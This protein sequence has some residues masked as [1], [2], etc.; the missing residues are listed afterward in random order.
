M[1]PDLIDK[2]IG[3][4]IFGIG[5]WIGHSLLFLTLMAVIV[6]S[7]LKYQKNTAWVDRYPSQRWV[8]LIYIGSLAHLLLD[9]PGINHV[10]VFWPFFGPFPDGSREGFLLGYRSARTMLTE[11]IGLGFL[12]YIGI[13]EKWEKIKW[14]GLGLLLTSYIVL[15]LIL[16][17]LLVGF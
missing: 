8:L 6:S 13:N 2:T 16:F 7:I 3:S 4:M 5:R 14:Y 15:F 9:L 12:V 17:A 10:V 1:L 11:V